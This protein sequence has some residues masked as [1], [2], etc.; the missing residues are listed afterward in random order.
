M[1]SI[2]P[3]YVVGEGGRACLPRNNGIHRNYSLLCLVRLE[4]TRL[5][6]PWLCGSYILVLG[7]R[8][9]WCLDHHHKHKE[10]VLDHMDQHHKH[11][12]FNKVISDSGQGDTTA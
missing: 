10:F 12:E 7:G 4:R 6:E 9:G 2:T 8:R 1:M 5:L 11:K 3:M